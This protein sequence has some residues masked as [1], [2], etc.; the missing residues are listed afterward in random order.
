M[1]PI[2]ERLWEV[3]GLFLISLRVDPD[4]EAVAGGVF[5]DMS[6]VST[7]TQLNYRAIVRQGVAQQIKN[8]LRKQVFALLTPNR[9]TTTRPTVVIQ[10][11][12]RVFLVSLFF[13]VNA[14]RSYQLIDP[15]SDAI[16]S[17]CM[18]NV[19]A[20]VLQQRCTLSFG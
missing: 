20:G 2:L 1:K 14:S 6:F 13:C 19:Y 16:Y 7:H 15:I 18:T 4:F 3:L 5:P 11:V 8:I 9:P 17:L 10:S 12:D